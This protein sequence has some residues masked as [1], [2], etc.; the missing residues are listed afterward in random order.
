MLEYSKIEIENLPKTFAVRKMTGKGEVTFNEIK[1]VGITF[2]EDL[3]ASPLT[4]FDVIVVWDEVTKDPLANFKSPT[5]NYRNPQVGYII[6]ATKDPKLRYVA[7]M[8]QASGADP[9][10]ILFAASEAEA[11][12][13]QKARRGLDSSLTG[14][15]LSFS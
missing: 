3:K 10:N 11:I 6:I 8:L 14:K 12:E 9:A 7:I 13:L 2:Q 5:Q 4:T 1:E 15:G